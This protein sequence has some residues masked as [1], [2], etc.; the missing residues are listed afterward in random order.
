[1]DQDDLPPRPADEGL[2]DTSFAGGLGASFAG[3]AWIAIFAVIAGLIL[4]GAMH[5]LR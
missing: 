2:D 5:W 3:V 4:W 1:M